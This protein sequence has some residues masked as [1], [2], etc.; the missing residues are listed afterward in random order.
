MSYLRFI[1]VAL[2]FLILPISCYAEEAKLGFIVPLTGSA[3]LMGD[4]LRGISQ[5][6]NFKHITPIFED[7]RCEGKSALSAYFKLKGKGVR[8]FYMACSGSIL[9]VAPHAKRN[10]DIIFTTYAGSSKIRDTGDEVI[11]LNPDALSIA[12]G[13][14]KLITADKRPV[15]ILYEEQE[16]ASSLVRR[17][18][19]ILGSEV[20][21]Q[22]SYRPDAGSFHAEILRMRSKDS[23]SI[24]F[25]PVGD[26]AA[27]TILRQISLNKIKRPII[28]EVNLCDFPFQPADF[29][30]HGSCVAAKFQGQRY[31]QFLS[32]YA[33]SA[34][35]PPAYPFYDAMA[36]DLFKQLDR[37]VGEGSAEVNSIKKRL[38][39]GFNGEFANYKFSPSGEASSGGDYLVR[40]DY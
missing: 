16:Y 2:L 18:V 31:T 11:R 9:A 4:S 15:T 24:I 5:L 8:L 22:I 23:R 17:L 29:N 7:D 30:L 1:P 33:T 21:D 35:R 40:S 39:A 14:A 28:G 13:V 26:A 20:V 32:S 38:L 34:G 6:S 25:V 12:E 36:L 27:R 10:G 3:V 19:E 37:I